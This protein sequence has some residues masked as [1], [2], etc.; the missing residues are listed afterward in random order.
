M[1]KKKKKKNASNLLEED[2]RK[3]TK[4]REDTKET[5]EMSR[6]CKADLFFLRW[7]TA[8]PSPWGNFTSPT[9][10]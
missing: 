4:K 3:F 6:H 8:D 7:M 2:L 5:V 1:L 9:K 10:Y